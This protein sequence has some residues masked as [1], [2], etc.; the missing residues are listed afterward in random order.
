MSTDDERDRTDGDI[1]D[2]HDPI[3][4]EFE[5]PADGYQPIPLTLIFLFFGL[6]GW[7]GWY[8]GAYSGDW[9][10]D[11]LYPGQRPTAGAAADES[12]EGNG[13]TE[14]LAKVGER[15][16]G[17]CTSCHQQDGQGLEGSFPPLDGSTWVTGS[18]EV[19][20]RI[21]LHGMEGAVEVAGSEYNGNMP[22]W[23]DQLSDREIAGVVSY[24]RSAWS[25]EA[26]SVE[27]SLVE[28]LREKTS[29]RSDPW[30]ADEL[31]SFRDQ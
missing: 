15:V 27:P 19:P 23:G 3:V 26:S 30:T 7:G 18:P 4:R 11:V 13:G 22:A 6:I 14:D 9:R 8:L 24:I 17:R 5:R 16:Y 20:V 21:L 25:N 29:D 1:H 28:S 12:D 10:V 31:E 2:L